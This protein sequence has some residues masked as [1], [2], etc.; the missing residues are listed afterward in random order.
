MPEETKDPEPRAAEKKKAYQP[1]VLVQYGSITD[2]T[3]GKN[4]S[5]ADLLAGA[6]R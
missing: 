5:G 3:K 6:K 2:L 1:P 4:S